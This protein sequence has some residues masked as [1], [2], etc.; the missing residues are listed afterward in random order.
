VSQKYLQH[1]PEVF[2]QYRE[3][4]KEALWWA[5]NNKETVS[6][7]ISERSGLELSVVKNVM[8][9]N[10]NWALFANERR[11]IDFSLTQQVLRILEECND[12]LIN[13]G[14]IS[15]DFD[16]KEKINFEVFNK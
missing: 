10:E 12:Y 14:Q 13:T 8:Q 11:R 6:R 2:T 1:F 15:V 7:W 4:L 16:V 9:L 3:A 5:S